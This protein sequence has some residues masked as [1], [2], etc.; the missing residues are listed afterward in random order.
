MLLR[1]TICLVL[2]TGLL[3][4]TTGYADVIPFFRGKRAPFVAGIDLSINKIPLEMALIFLNSENKEKIVE[5][6]NGTSDFSILEH[7]TI[8]LAPKKQLSTPFSKQHDMPK[9]IPLRTIVRGD[10]PSTYNGQVP[11]LCLCCS[12]EKTK[13]SYALSCTSKQF[14][15]DARKCQ[16]CS[17]LK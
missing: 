7:G 16:P 17:D 4:S 9:L 12:V 14:S 3:M 2:L 10:I 8:Y 11:P 15:Y 5:N 6:Q 1:K 13:D